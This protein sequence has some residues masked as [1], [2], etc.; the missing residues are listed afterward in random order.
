MSVRKTCPFQPAIP[1]VGKVSPNVTDMQGHAALQIQR[2]VCDQ[3]NCR[4]WSIK[5]KD[6]RR[7]LKG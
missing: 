6:C 3:E 2:V 1:V 5:K 4:S 7:L